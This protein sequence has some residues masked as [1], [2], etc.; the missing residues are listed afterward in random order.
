MH[1]FHERCVQRQ[2]KT[3][4]ERKDAYTMQVL[5]EWNSFRWSRSTLLSDPEAKM[6]K[7]KVHMFPDSV[8]CVGAS[9]PDPSNGQQ[10]WRTCGTNTDVSNSYFGSPRRANHFAR[11]PWCFHSDHIHVDVQRHS[12]GGTRESCL[13][14]VK[15]VAAFA[16]HFKPGHWRKLVQEGLHS[17]FFHNSRNLA[18]SSQEF[19]HAISETAREREGGK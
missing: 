6:I 12:N 17:T 10:F 11:I 9:N 16:T 13:C 19:R 3:L 5:Q 15:Q 8:L 2:L 7:M 1:D 4:S 14:N 18:S